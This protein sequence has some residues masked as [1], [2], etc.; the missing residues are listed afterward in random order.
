MTVQETLK[1]RQNGKIGI[2]DRFHGHI[3]LQDHQ[4]YPHLGCVGMISPVTLLK[5]LDDGD[6]NQYSQ[7]ELDCISSCG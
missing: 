3:I 7:S 4:R 6:C 5:K 2:G 1:R